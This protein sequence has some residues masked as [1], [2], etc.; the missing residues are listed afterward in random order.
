MITVPQPVVPGERLSAAKTNAIIDTLRRLRPIPGQGIALEE[1]PSGIVVSAAQHAASAP[2]ASVSFRVTADRAAGKALRIA[3]DKGRLCTVGQQLCRELALTLQQP[4]SLTEQNGRWY[5]TL[6]EDATLYIAPKEDTED[7]YELRLGSID[8]STPVTARIADIRPSAESPVTQHILGDLYLSK[9]SEAPTPAA[10]TVAL[11]SV[12]EGTSGTAS[13]KWQIFSPTW[14]L[15]SKNGADR[16]QTLATADWYPL[17]FTPSATTV[18]YAVL[19]Y[20]VSCST[21]ETT[22]NGLTVRDSLDDMTETELVLPT[23]GP[24]SSAN[25]G[26]DGHYFYYVKIAQ[27]NSPDTEGGPLTVSQIHLGA[28]VEDVGI[29]RGQ[30]GAQGP[31]GE[32]GD[33]GANGTDGTDGVDGDTYTPSLREVTGTGGGVYLDFTSANTGAVIAGTVDIRGPQGEQ[34]EQGPQGPQ[35]PKGPKGDPGDGA[36]LGSPLSLSVVTGVQYSTT[37]HKLTATVRKITFYG[38]LGAASTVDI[39]TATPHSG[40]H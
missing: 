36:D 14:V 22:V 29:T 16:T 28:I 20:T 37:T 10:W 30:K 24:G 25:P 8:G 3:V 18:V 12:Q 6:T 34:G 9:T 39:T 11:R 7:A 5:A 15:K 40:E 23:D 21:L 31:Q 26:T 32:K 1:T 17:P 33:P 4:G 2:P 27:F 19:E 13:Q 38:T 35:G